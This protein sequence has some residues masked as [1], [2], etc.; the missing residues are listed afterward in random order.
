MQPA[1]ELVLIYT[2]V[3]LSTTHP[4]HPCW[5]HEM[6]PESWNNAICLRLIIL[7]GAGSAQPGKSVAFIK[8]SN[9]IKMTSSLGKALNCRSRRLSVFLFSWIIIFRW[10][11]L[12]SV[13]SGRVC[14]W[15]FV[16]IIHCNS[17]SLNKVSGSTSFDFSA[18]RRQK[19]G[20][21][22]VADP[23]SIFWSKQTS[24]SIVR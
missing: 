8:F 13:A 15:L 24:T 22:S 2:I 16:Q 5:T 9:E 23:S 6:Y 14:N 20:K 10:W 3:T 12:E 11:M 4:P 1:S 17:F 19:S 18:S 21:L 7:A